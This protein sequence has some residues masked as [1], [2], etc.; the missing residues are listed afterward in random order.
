MQHDQSAHR[1]NDNGHEH[2]RDRTRTA[3]ARRRSVDMRRARADKRAELRAFGGS[4]S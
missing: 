3:T 1:T 4:T 2:A